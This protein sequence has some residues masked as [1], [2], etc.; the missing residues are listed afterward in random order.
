MQSGRY[1]QLE[2]TVQAGHGEYL[3]GDGLSGGVGLAIADGAT[4]SIGFTPQTQRFTFTLDTDGNGAA[5]TY[6]IDGVTADFATQLAAVASEINEVNG[7][8]ATVVDS[9]LQIANNRGDG[10][11]LNFGTADA[12]VSDAIDAVAAGAAYFKS[13]LPAGASLDLDTDAINLANGGAGMSSDGMLADAIDISTLADAYEVPAFDL[14][15]EGDQIVVVPVAG[16]DSPAVATNAISLAKQRYTL[17]NLPGEDLIMI[18][19][20]AGARRLSV[21]YDMLPEVALQPQRDIEIRV[22]DIDAG[23]ITYFDVETGTSLATRQLGEEQKATALDFDVAFTGRLAA[24]DEFLISGNRDGIGDNRNINSLLAL[25]SEDLM[26]AGSGGFQKVFSAT[27]AKLGALVQSGKIAADSAIALR[28]ASLE[29][30][31]KFTGVNL[32]TEAAN[33]IEQ[34]QAYQASARVLATARE[35]FETLIQTV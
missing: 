1:F 24:N 19:G 17:S 21:Q 11:A 31:S 35:L 18:V 28:D 16:A 3:T 9:S 22:T 34:Q 12:L 29:A 25:Q 26:G 6:I 33:L 30:E 20:D 13:S 23:E 15:R 32:D 27:V 8:T 10:S 2:R 14:R 7:L 4:G 5:E